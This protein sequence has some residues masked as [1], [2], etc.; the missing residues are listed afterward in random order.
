M[1]FFKRKINKVAETQP[2][3]IRDYSSS[4]I[5]LLTNDS[6]SFSCIDKIACEFAGLNYAIYDQE[7]KQKVKNKLLNVIKQP[8]LE[9]RHFNFFYQSAVDYFNGGC[10]WLKSVINGEIISLFRLNPSQV[11]TKR[12]D[13][14]NEK[15]YLYNGNIYTSKNIV[16]I[17]SRFSYSTLRGGQSIFDAV[18]SV[19][20]TANEL[21][22]YTQAS[23]SNGGLGKRLVIDVQGAFPNITDEQAQELKSNFI[24]SYSGAKNAGKPLLK[25]KGFEYTELGSNVDNKSAELSENRKFQEHEISKIFGVPEG[26]L[27]VSEK[28]NLENI[29]TLLNEFAIKPLATQF[30]EAIN[31][32]LDEERYFFEFDYNGLMKVSLQQRID[33]YIKQITNG[34]LSPNE[35]RAKENLAPIEAGDNH[36]MPVNLMPLNEE[37]INAYMAKQKNEAEKGNKKTENPTDK[38]AQHF[39]GGDDKQ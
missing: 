25:K 5:S 3:V 35:A 30:Q 21:D 16:F 9:D 27:T 36:F 37:T 19:F 4:S 1:V 31:S 33:A 28:I 34:L 24:S 12:N 22:N 10:Y 6:T 11:I 39:G 17:P 15:E 38:D 13:I 18:D 20:R 26:I 32:M 14:T 8:N 29:F 2:K 23:F 7:N